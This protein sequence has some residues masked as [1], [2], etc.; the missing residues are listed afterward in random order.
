MN[1][2]TLKNIKLAL[3]ILCFA[4]LALP[5]N[6]DVHTNNW[7]FGVNYIFDL[8]A[9]NDDKEGLYWFLYYLILYIIPSV[10]EILFWRFS[11]KGVISD[12]FDV[13]A[14]TFS[15]TVMFCFYISLKYSPVGIMVVMILQGA[16][17]AI[18]CVRLIMRIFSQDYFNDFTEVMRKKQ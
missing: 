13:I 9:K 12:V 18:A 2:K 8:F 11:K 3:Y 5:M 15:A 14:G 17:V 16:V 7:T 6:F 1:N 10:A 4:S